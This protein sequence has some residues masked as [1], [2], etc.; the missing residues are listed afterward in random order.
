MFLS[1]VESGHDER[2]RERLRRIADAV[3]HVD[4]ID[5]ALAYRPELWGD[6]HRLINEMVTR[7]PSDW[8]FGERELLATLVSARNQCPF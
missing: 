7:G 5:R 3:G 4:G 6:P 2:G 1:T 8:T